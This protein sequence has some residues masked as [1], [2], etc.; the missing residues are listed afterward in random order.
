[1]RVLMVIGGMAPRLGGPPKVAAQQALELTR[2]NLSI[3]IASVERPGEEAETLRSWQD[4]CDAG[5]KLHL[6]PRVFPQPLGFS[7]KLCRFL[8]AQ[9]PTY[10]IL[11]LHGVWEQCLAYAGMVARRAGIPYVVSPHGMLDRWSRARSRLKKSI[12]S[13]VV[14]TGRM[15]RGAAGIQF[16]TQGEREEA[17]EL[18]LPARAF[19][20]PNGIF[21]DRFQKLP[22]EKLAPLW[23]AC[24]GLEGKSPIILFFSRFHPKKGLHL[25][26]D[27]FAR[28]APRFPQAA[29]LAAGIA[30]DEK[31]LKDQLDR[32]ARPDLAGRAFITTEFTGDR[33]PIAL[34]AA[35]IFT[36]P[37]FQEGFSIAI[38][39]AMASAL[40]ML[41][42][43]Q[44]H[45]D[46]MEKENAG[47]VVPATVEGVAE[48]LERLLRLSPAE[49]VAT[50]QNAR[51]WA[52]R[53]FS[54]ERLGAKIQT[55]YE[56][57]RE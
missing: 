45:M 47:C 12:S 9:A 10:D 35:D 25:L 40:P 32:I 38:V 4:L 44:C 17:A 50:G 21:G 26:L 42:T 52:I 39:E 53:D 51:A 24:R 55:M 54:W 33:G 3:D 20:I 11:H 28:V 13:R 16:G 49:R 15:L 31:Y 36:Q 37:S 34:S 5:V 8:S 29:V 2:R 23:A 30:Q 48:G 41:V 6:F 46:E 22:P 27:A 14:G 57:C 43:D 7:P 56:S 19:I 18:G 1:M